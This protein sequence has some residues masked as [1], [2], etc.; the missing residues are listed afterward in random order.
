MSNLLDREIVGLEIALGQELPEDKK[1]RAEA[2]LA[3]LRGQANRGNTE[4]TVVMTAAEKS[5]GH[6]PRHFHRPST[7]KQS[8]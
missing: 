3:R 6:T 4:D 2:K 1:K 8:H 7:A 5:G